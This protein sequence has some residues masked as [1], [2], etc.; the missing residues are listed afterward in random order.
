MVGWHDQLN[1]DEFEQTPGDGE[2]QGS[3]MCC[4]PRGHKEL[5]TAERLSNNKYLQSKFSEEDFVYSYSLIKLCKL[6]K[7]VI[8]FHIYKN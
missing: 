2:G 6:L 5:D 1:G 3:L 8:Y 7:F 4:S